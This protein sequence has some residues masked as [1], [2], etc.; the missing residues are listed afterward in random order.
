M[1]EAEFR[2]YKYK[3]IKIRVSCKQ[4]YCHFIN[5]IQ[6]FGA[7]VKKEGHDL[8]FVLANTF[9]GKILFMALGSTNIRAF[10]AEHTEAGAI[11]D[12][13]SG[14]GP[15]YIGA[16]RCSP[17]PS[18]VPMLHRCMEMASYHHPPLS[19]SGIRVFPILLSQYCNRHDSSRQVTLHKAIKP[20]TLPLGPKVSA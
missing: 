13:G 7:F 9:C 18:R 17:T 16:S 15:N 20:S 3:I 5:K 1:L 4:P 8:Y 11:V 12:A 10:Q 6:L 14:V 19:H 2:K